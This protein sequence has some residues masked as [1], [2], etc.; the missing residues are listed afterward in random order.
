MNILKIIRPPRIVI[1][2]LI[3]LIVV[4]HLFPQDRPW[5]KKELQKL[6]LDIVEE[7]VTAFEP[8]WQDDSKR[9]PNSGFFDPRK[10]KDW[11][12]GYPG[13]AGIVTIP[14]NG[15]VTFCYSL[16]LKETDKASF[17]AKKVPRSVILD[18]ALKSIRWCCLTSVYVKNRYPYIF[19]DTAPQFL[20]GQYWRRQFGYRADEVGFLTMAIANLWEY[21]DQETRSLAE[22]VLIG[23]APKERL[24]RTWEYKQ[25]GNHDQVKQDLS[26]T[27]GAAF[28]FPWRPDQK[29]YWNIVALNGIDLVSTLHDFAN[30]TIVLGQPLNKFAK[31]WNLY[32]DYSSDHHGWA[33]IWYGS[34]IIFE[35]Y[36]Y[37]TLLS[38]M[39]GIP[40]PE[41]F[42]YPGNGFEG[43]SDRMKVICLPEG[44]P[45]SVHGME[46]DSYY[47]SG[48]LAY[49]YRSL[50]KQDR[51]AAA[52]E[53]RAA[54]LLKKHSLALPVYD[55]H[56]NNHGKAALAY[57]AHKYKPEYPDPLNFSE[58]W[59]A[60][61]GTFHHP[62]WQNIIHRDHRKFVSFS[63][64][65]ISSSGEHFGDIES[66]VCSFIVPAR[67]KQTV[68][69]PL[70]Y[71]HPHS[72][73]GEIDVT[74]S[75]GEVIQ[76]PTSASFYQLNNDDSQF[77]TSGLSVT[78]PIEQRIAFF[79]FGDGPCVLMNLFR[80]KDECRLSWSGIPVYFYERK[81]LTG[82][83]YYYD[84]RGQRILGAP[85]KNRTNWWSVDQLLGAAFLGGT[86]EIEIK[87]IVGRNWARTDEYKDKCET[88]FYSPLKNLALNK[89]QTGGDIISIF[90]PEKKPAEIARVAAEIGQQKL[91]LPQG[92]KGLVV[93]EDQDGIPPRYLAVANL[94]GT[95][96][97]A[98]TTL[99]F[100]CGAPILSLPSVVEGK[101]SRVNF[102]LNPFET[103]GET[104]T[105]Y[106]EVLSKEPVIISKQKLGRY[107]IK[108]YE[109]SEAMIKF[110]FCRQ[111]ELIQLV[112][113]EGNIIQEIRPEKPGQLTSI[114]IKV[115]QEILLINKTEV[116]SDV[117]PPAIEIS[118][119]I[120]REDGRIG[121]NIKAKDQSGI[122]WVEV[123]VDGEMVAKI[124][125]AP[126][127]WVGWPG[128]G[129]HTFRVKAQD[130]S[131]RANISTSSPRTIFIS[132]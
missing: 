12:P 127:H 59:E 11:T 19:K 96:R 1:F 51:V 95:E 8:I 35:A 131:P 54:Q 116:E 64:G 4:S 97:L 67:L 107:L 124:N 66:G 114:A 46:Y 81:G 69:E 40:V 92:W 29:S 49:L 15:L 26:S 85:Y 48:L 27:I 83:K 101:K 103:F 22:E 5:S 18:H 78:G 38:Q 89:G 100:H 90:M 84:T 6:Y 71:L 125:K 14:L 77:H 20:D 65:T 122:E 102:Q 47:G 24:I 60:L 45:A 52:L 76:G 88:V 128:K 104:I 126:W 80:A 31:G 120:V 117:F 50:F 79:S 74:N 61:G 129:Y 68:L 121:L 87:K 99:E 109:N 93:T 7:A 3:I 75:K 32:Q 91:P 115:N 53:Q 58:A 13:Y 94:D 10:Y 57:L 41:T 2:S 73:T 17:T 111:P 21:L 86:G 112:T 123:Y 106:A 28:I 130:S 56:R 42:L 63:W 62:W 110:H 72:I 119:L 113:T 132:Q 44:D 55:Y 9:V 33:Q 43:V 23:G 16:L 37:V 25:G 118:D 108:P 39:T 98:T 105:A 82:E 70:I 34:E 30:N 36:F